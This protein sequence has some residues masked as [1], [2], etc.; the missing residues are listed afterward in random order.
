MGATITLD[1]MRVFKTARRY[2]GEALLPSGTCVYDTDFI[3]HVMT[4]SW[5]LASP[6]IRESKRCRYIDAIDAGYGRFVSLGVA[7]RRG[8]RFVSWGLPRISNLVFA[9]RNT[10]APSRICEHE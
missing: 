3:G 5:N 7:Y 6:R 2:D 9:P 1:A 8:V 10:F 4:A